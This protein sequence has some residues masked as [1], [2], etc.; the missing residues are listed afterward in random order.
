[1]PFAN[2]LPE[3]SVAPGASD[4][5]WIAACRDSL[6]KK[7]TTAKVPQEQAENK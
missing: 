7:K 3:L 4:V 1:M 2:V 6:G 5:C